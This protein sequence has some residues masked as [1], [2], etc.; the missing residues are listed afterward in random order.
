MQAR[1][2][3]IGLVDFIAKKMPPG[4]PSKCASTDNCAANT[5]A[6]MLSLA[7]QSAASCN[8]SA[9]PYGMRAVRLLTSRELKNSLIDLGIAQSGEVTDDLLTQDA[10]YTKSKFPIHTHVTTAIDDNRNDAMMLLA[11]KISATAASRLRN[12]W[13]CGTNATN[14]ANSFLTLAERI[15]RRPLTD[16]EKSTYN[17][18]FTKYGAQVGSEIALAAAITSPQFLYRSELGTKVSDARNNASNFGTQLNLQ[19]LDQSAYILD[20]YEYATLLAYMYTGST[21]DQ[22]LMQAAK[23]NQLNSESAVNSQIDRLL[24][25]TRGREHL[26]E[27]GANWVRTDD[28]LKAVRSA[29]PEFTDDIKNDMAKEVRELFGYVFFTSNTPFTQFYGGDYSVINSRLA[30]YYGVSGFSGGTSDWKATNIPNR[31]GILGTGAFSVG[32][33]QPDRSGPIKKAVDIRELMLCHHIGAPPTDLNTTSKRAELVKAAQQREDVTGDLT[34]RE[35]YEII[36]ND[37]ACDSCHQSRINPLFG[38]DDIDHL[39]KFRTTMRGLGPNGQYNLPVNN[40]GELIGLAS[41][42]D[43]ASL[44]FQGSKDLGKKMSTLSSVSEC[45]A[46]NSF[47]WATGMPLNSNSYSTLEGGQDNEPA[48]LTK[49]QEESFAC[50]EKSLMDTY[51]ANNSSAKSLYRKIGTLDL[52]R[53]RKPIDSS[54]VKQ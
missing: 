17:G 7:S 35:Y 40:F 18:F 43:P 54:Q 53:V 52:V 3:D 32:N 26:T 24:Q 51:A 9:Q 29:N 14:C 10:T 12:T 1:L 2:G 46:V 6:Y 20:N 33:S 19:N 37:P 25:T 22:T 49:N 39:G 42:D 38:I 45:L 11:D 13:G 8:T 27:F 31:G 34:T 23:N 44:T 4:N 5:A 16:A 30:Q 15:F 21:P 50:A 47:R 48:K 28:V 41:I 36:T